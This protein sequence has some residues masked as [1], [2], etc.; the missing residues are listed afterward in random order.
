MLLM[1][2]VSVIL[3]LK[4][5]SVKV[6]HYLT[7]SDEYYEQKANLFHMNVSLRLYYRLFEEIWA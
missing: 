3:K 7:N 4:T 2:I 1:V 5:K 6:P